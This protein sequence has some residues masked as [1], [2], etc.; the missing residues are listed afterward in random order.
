M[1][2][3]LGGYSNFR[4]RYEVPIMK[5][6]DRNA[7]AEFKRRISP[8]KLRRL[9]SQVATELPDKIPMERY[10][11]LTA[12]Q[13]RLYKQ[14]ASAEQEKI[15]N[16]PDTKIRIDTSI[17]TAILRLKQ[18]CCHPSLFTKDQEGIYGRS[19]KLEAFLE[20]LDE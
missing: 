9:K 17:L 2:S 4:D 12:E 14:F 8:F 3:Y 13:V 10:C 1:P 20:I 15:K 18:I 16:L 6:G 5:R 7:T 19:G 11:E